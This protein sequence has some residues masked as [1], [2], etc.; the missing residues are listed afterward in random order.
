MHFLRISAVVIISQALCGCMSSLY[1]GV[2]TRYT[3]TLQYS[4]DR[5]NGNALTG[6]SLLIL[7]VLTRSGPD[8]ARFPSPSSIA[9]FLQENHDDLQFVYP[10]EFEKKYRSTSGHDATAMDRFY[11]SL[12][13][14]EMLAVQTSDSIWKAVDA[15]YLL[16]L[17]VTY[18][19]VVRGFDGM[20]NKR[21]TMEAELW[22]VA[23][24]EAVWRSEVVGVERG[25]GADRTF[26]LGAVRKVLGA[27]PG[28]LPANNEKDW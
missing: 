9:G 6:Q 18:A 28:F 13:N 27:I 3:V 4:S 7:P 2:A 26:I 17:R 10:E 14:R 19:A 23:A 25:A 11:R 1:H 16:S 5:L 12:F 8:T 20:V 21:I 15:H 22:E 24:S